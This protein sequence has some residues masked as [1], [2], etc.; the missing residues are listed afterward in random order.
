MITRYTVVSEG[1]EYVLL[2][3]STGVAAKSWTW[4]ESHSL[5]RVSL[6]DVERLRDLFLAQEPGLGKS[7][8]PRESR[9]LYEILRSMGAPEEQ[10]LRRLGRHMP[11]KCV[12][13]KQL[14][15]D[16]YSGPR[17]ESCHEQFV[18][19][20]RV[21]NGINNVSRKSRGTRRR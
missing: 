6:A 18:R 12:G 13:C 4:V 19:T 5:D 3:K 10:I 11:R 21:R 17:C 15:T 20:G 9:R 2:C 8:A 16:G 7:A 1:Q 14:T